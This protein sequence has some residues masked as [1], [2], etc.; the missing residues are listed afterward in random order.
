MDLFIFLVS[1]KDFLFSH[2]LNR[3]KVV[4]VLKVFFI[5]LEKMSILL[6]L[7]LSHEWVLNFCQM[8]LLML[9]YDFPNNL[10]KL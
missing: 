6:L 10:L 3:C 5:G 8:Y 4:G 1:A 2:H 9:P 7:N